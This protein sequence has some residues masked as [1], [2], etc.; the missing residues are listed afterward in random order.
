MNGTWIVPFKGR[1]QSGPYN[2]N[3]LWR[4]SSIYVMDNHRAAL[5]CWIQ[6]LDLNSPHSILHIDRHTDTLQ[7]P[8]EEWL[9]NLPLSWEL[10][11][12]GYL[13]QTCKA[14]D[15]LGDVPVFRWDNYLSIYF[16]K[17]SSAIKSCYFATHEN[18]DA[19]DYHPVCKVDLWSLPYYFRECLDE[20]HGPWI[21][22]I[23]LD[24]FFWKDW[25]S[26]DMMVSEAYL[27]ACF[28][29]LR[30]KIDDGVVKATTICLTHHEDF[31]G[32]WKKSEDLAKRIL[33]YLSI[34]FHLPSSP[35]Y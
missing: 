16:A 12:E 21:V 15:L 5:W 4:D 8:T 13:H 10:T 34:D 17:F 33:T 32:G 6:E 28:K 24:Y 1:N 7:L 35:N 29:S 27:S 26:I 20:S 3:F 18:G 14:N 31:T 30:K 9:K 2:Q 22:N 23:D 25:E 11:I 19:P